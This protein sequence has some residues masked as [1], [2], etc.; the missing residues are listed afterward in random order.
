MDLVLGAPCIG[1]LR[2]PHAFIG[3][4]RAYSGAVGAH[5]RPCGLEGSPFST[6]KRPFCVGATET[7]VEQDGYEKGR[8]SAKGVLQRSAGS[9][10]TL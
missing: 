3:T 4:T 1:D 8:H 7:L 6:L 10:T 9:Y 5:R 2:T